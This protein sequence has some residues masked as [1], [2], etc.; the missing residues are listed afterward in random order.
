MN[1]TDLI[2]ACKAYADRQDI[3]VDNNLDNFILMA[4]A[5]I[6][7][8]LK[9]REQTARVYAPTR[10]G[11]EYYSLPPDY[12]G[13][14]D[15][16]LNDGLPHEDHKTT[17]FD[18]L[19]PQQFNIRR[20]QEYC[21]KLYYTIIADQIQIFPKQDAGLS[22]EIIYY[23]KVPNLNDTENSNWLSTEHPDIYLAGV[24]AE[25]EIF[26][27]NYDV[28]QSWRDRMSEAINELEQ[29]D[30]VERWSGSPLVTKVG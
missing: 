27:K 1:Y 15:I 17:P 30:E 9:T 4:E 6:N 25:I 3:E 7:R 13:M 26:A 20:D 28:G 23:Q 5:R 21:N 10:D 2:S 24:T 29:S 19:N 14:R 12:R 11:T 8:L 22:L 18:Y 16:K